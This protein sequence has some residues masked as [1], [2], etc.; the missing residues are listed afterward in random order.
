MVPVKKKKM[1]PLT[2]GGK[3]SYKNQEKC[4][5]CEEKFCMDKDDKYYINR[6]KVKDHCHYTG[7]FRRAAHSKCNLNYKVPKD[8]PIIIHNAS[9]DSS[10]MTHFIINQLAEEFKGELN[11]I[12][13]NME[14]YITFSVPIKK[15]GDNNKKIAYKLRFIDSFR[16]MSTS[17]SELVDNMSGIFNS[18]ECKSCI[19]KIKINSECCFV[20]LK[21]KRLI[22]KCK[23]C[24][25]EWK[26][27]INEL[28]ENFSSVYQF[29]NSDLNKFVFLLRK[30]VYP[31]EHLD[32]WKNLIEIYYH[33]KK[34]F[35]VI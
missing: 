3:T 10:I 18:I 28:I 34:L 23:K 15:E 22:Y 32:N 16:F 21:N 29:C 31:Y 27:P 33:L 4:H 9:Y 12:G 35:I 19:E 8:I 20:G 6:K 14:K 25:E 1:V 7:K 11:C 26:R 2:K 5:I 17:L 13:E 24:R 30:G